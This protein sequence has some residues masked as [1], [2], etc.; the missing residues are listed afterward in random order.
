M[1]AKRRISRSRKSALSREVMRALEVVR[2]VENVEYCSEVICIVAVDDSGKCLG[3]E[4]GKRVRGERTED[5]VGD[6]GTV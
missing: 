3:L 5:L 1:S 4:C 2:R 6:E